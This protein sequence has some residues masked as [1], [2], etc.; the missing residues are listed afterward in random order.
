MPQGKSSYDH[1][2]HGHER[3]FDARKRAGHSSSLTVQHGANTVPK[4]EG[5]LQ[6][7]VRIWMLATLK[8]LVRIHLPSLACR[9]CAFSQVCD[10]CEADP[11]CRQVTSSRTG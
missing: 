6:E 10:A 3:P 1:K 2:E 8:E 9:C 5:R 11:Q 7:G 4:E